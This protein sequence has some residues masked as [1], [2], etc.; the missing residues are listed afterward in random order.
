MTTYL[1]VILFCYSVFNT[2]RVQ[3]LQQAY[4][5]IANFDLYRYHATNYTGYFKKILDYT[6]LMQDNIWTIFQLQ[7]I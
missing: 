4:F 3:D 5:F 1:Q 2:F 6:S 7:P